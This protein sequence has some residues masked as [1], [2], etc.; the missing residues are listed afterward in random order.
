MTS[1]KE[2]SQE[3]KHCIDIE[4]D[5]LKNIC[6]LPN[7]VAVIES[8]KTHSEV[9]PSIMKYFLD[10]GYNIH[11][12]CLK[13]HTKMN[14]LSRCNFDKTKIEIFSFP[15]MP[16][17]QSFFDMF[18]AYSL[19]FV[20]TIFTHNGY[21]F[22]N[23]LEKLYMKK[24][25]KNNV[26]CIDHDFTSVEKNIQTIEQRFLDNHKVFVLRDGIAYKGAMLPFLTASYFGE[27]ISNDKLNKIRT[28][29]CVGGGG[30]KAILEILH[31]FFLLSTH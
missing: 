25:Q 8:H 24:Y 19:I 28:F 10:L 17:T 29:V 22:I 1:K 2:I 27:Y 13:E 30:Y 21:S 31:C 11:L 4:L 6:I 26:Y 7:T 18:N 9:Y 14:P 23:A 16:E 12:F 3:D 15:T 5:K 20:A